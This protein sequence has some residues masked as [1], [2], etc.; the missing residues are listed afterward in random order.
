[1]EYSDFNRILTEISRGFHNSESESNNYIVGI[2]GIDCAGKSTLLGELEQ[3]L[4]RQG[5]ACVCISGDDFLLEPKIRNAN[6]DQALGYYDES[7]D[8]HT[9]FH[10]IL[11]PARNAL[12]YHKNISIS[13]WLNDRMVDAELK[14]N[15]PCVVLVEGVFIFKRSLPDVFDYRIWIEL[16]FEEGLGRALERPRDRAHYGSEE[17]IRARYLER[18]YKGQRLHLQLDRPL[19]TCNAIMKSESRDFK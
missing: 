10:E 3:F 8:Y 5:I 7:F 1:M 6:P 2:S 16:S 9:L 4:T 14:I 17:R 13:D 11:V 12:H 15:G 19:E 18:L